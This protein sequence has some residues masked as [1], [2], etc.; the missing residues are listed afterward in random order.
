MLAR[1]GLWKENQCPRVTEVPS[2][3]VLLL[4]LGFWDPVWWAAGRRPERPSG[5]IRAL[6]ALCGHDVEA[7]AERRGASAGAAKTRRG[8][9]GARSGW[10]APVP[11]P[12]P[13]GPSPQPPRS[14]RVENPEFGGRGAR[15]ERLPQSRGLPPLPRDPPWPTP[16]DGRVFILGSHLR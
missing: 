8:V 13:R 6:A 3:N 7:L 11:Q 5:R 16:R 12:R 14:P 2:Q 15:T 10:A 9:R 1:S 4:R